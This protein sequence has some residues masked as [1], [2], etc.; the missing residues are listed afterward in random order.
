MKGNQFRKHLKWNLRNKLRYRFLKFRIGKMGE[1]V[2]IDDNVKL[3][4]FP[5]NISIDSYAVLKE[6]VRICSCN[7][8]ASIKIGKNTTIGYHTFIFASNS[9]KIGDNC[10]IAPFVYLVDSDHNIN[11]NQL[12]NQQSNISE[13]IGIGN[14]V[15]IGTGAKIL[16]GV[17]IGDGAVIAAG[18]VVNQNVGPYEIIGG[19]PGRKI[20]ERK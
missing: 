13:P 14:D 16:K 6:G 5:Q 2:F 10:L 15:W 19:I 8:N 18:S 12:I 7:E 1:S 4:R 17:T 3:M 9:I 20:S 11:R